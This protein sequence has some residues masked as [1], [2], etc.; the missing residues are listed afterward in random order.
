MK[1]T[2]ILIGIV[3]PSLLMAQLDRSVKP[4]ASIAPSPNIKDSEVFQTANGITVIVSENHKL[5]R[6]SFDF[7]MG[8]DPIIEGDKAGLADLT[9]S[10]LL[11]GTKNRTKDQLDNEKD[12]IGASLSA[13]SNSIYLSCLTKHLDKGLNL[14]S[15]VLLHANFPESE[16]NRVKKQNE[17]GLL[18]AKSDPGT[19]ADNAE[20]KANFKNHPFGGVMSEATLQQIKREDVVKYYSETFTPKGSYLVIVGDITKEQAEKLVNSYFASWEGNAPYKMKSGDGQFNKGNRVIFVKK[21]GAVQSVIQIS[22]PMKLRTGDA[23][24]LPL[25]VLNGIL[26]GGGFGNRLMQNLRED[27]AYTYGCYSSLNITE[28]GS[29]MSIGGNFRND[30]TDSAITQI[31]FEVDNIAN[32]YVKDE[33]LNLTKSSM[34]GSFARSFERPQTIARFALN[35][36]KNNLDKDYYKTYLERLEAVDKDAILT[37]AQ[38][39]LTASNCNIVIV[40]NEEII[41]KVKRFDADGKIEF[42]DAYGNELKDIKKATIT[43]EELIDKHVL[44]VTQTTSMKAAMKKIKKIKTVEEITELTMS[45]IP[46]PLLSTKLW[47][48]PNKEGQKL[49]GQ[50]MVLQKTYFDGSTGSNFNMQ[51]GAKEFT[52]EEIAEKKQI[53]GFIPELNYAANGVQSELVGIENQNGKDFY[54]LKVTNGATETF[55]YFDTNTF[56]KAKTLSIQKRGEE[57]NESSSEFSNFKEVGGLL[58]PHQLLISMGQVSFSGKTTSIVINGKSDLKSFK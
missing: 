50:G 44:A 26:G 39:Y 38:K 58:F 56:L 51:M 17:S 35:I 31:L 13:T 45:Q 42:L 54:V 6:V 10:L 16:F 8:S 33:E 24:Q 46:F 11:S 7:V 37:M 27:K 55:D 41:E 34:N 5:P 3:L 22:F 2:L 19:M 49:E 29:W 57:V 25:T 20:K 40:G 9:G 48:A 1:K 36:I 52:A 43:K 30:V 53:M 21:P 47:M 12:Y 15:D 32:G 14:L 28:D 18:A 23:D 4:K